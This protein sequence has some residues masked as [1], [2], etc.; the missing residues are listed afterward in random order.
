M[1]PIL[2]FIQKIATPKG[3][4]ILFAL[5]VVVFGA[6]LLTLAQLTAHTGGIGILDFDRGYTA[7][8]VAEVF[9]SYGKQGMA[10]YTRIQ[11]LDLLNP[12]LYSLFF[13]AIIHLLWRNHSAIAAWIVL[14]PF[15]A[16][17]LDYAENVTLFLLTR[18][19]PKLSTE[20]VRLSSTLS[21]IKNFALIP[22]IIVLLIG[23]VL[24]AMHRFKR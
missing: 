24:F 15:W 6:I 1:N 5:Y 2:L 3:F 20:L 7:E 13:A 17:L 10:L 14:F 19:Y 16:G 8:R 18:S 12:A 4:A 22:A 9:G 23:L 11:L 21:I